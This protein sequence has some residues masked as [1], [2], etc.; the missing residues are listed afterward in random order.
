M[1]FLFIGT[2]V[3]IKSL[4]YFSKDN[5][6][7]KMVFCLLGVFLC[8]VG[9][10][11]PVSGYQNT[12]VLEE[13]MLEKILPQE[14]KYVIQTKD[15]A[16]KYVIKEKMDDQKEKKVTYSNANVEVVVIEKAIRPVIKKYSL[17]PR[18]TAFTFALLPEKIEYKIFLNENDIKRE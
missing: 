7:K 6:S 14:N 18:R 4:F 17:K 10:F 15:N 5:Q 9:V 16:V 2:C 8:L 3:I 1:V 12:G 13:R 11:C